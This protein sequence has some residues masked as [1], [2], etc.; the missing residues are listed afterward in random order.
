MGGAAIAQQP[1]GM[2]VS[3]DQQTIRAFQLSK[4]LA[5]SEASRPVA[6]AVQ[7]EECLRAGAYEPIP[8]SE[9]RSHEHEGHEDQP[10]PPA[11][12]GFLIEEGEDERR[13]DQHPDPCAETY[14]K[15]HPAE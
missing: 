6:V 3:P 1:P 2:G 14:P 11:C 13:S 7:P 15:D 10:V 4:L 9:G 12:S 5:V 8:K